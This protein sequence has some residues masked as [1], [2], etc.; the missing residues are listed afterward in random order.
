MKTR[1]ILP[2]IAISAWACANG[3]GNSSENRPTGSGNTSTSAGANTPSSSNSSSGNENSNSS[4]GGSNVGTGGDTGIGGSGPSSSSSSGGGGSNSSASGG[5]GPVANGKGESC[6]DLADLAKLSQVGGSKDFSNTLSDSYGASDDYNPYMP[7][8]KQPGC[9]PV[10]DALGYER[11]YALTLNPGDIFKA[12]LAAVPNK[13][14][15]AIYVLDDCQALSWPD[16]D[17]ST[18]CGSNEYKSQGF[19]GALGCYP[20][21]FSFE[22]P[23]LLNQK[24]TKTKTFY[25]VVDQV[26]GVDAASFVLEW[27]ID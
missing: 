21:D 12:R 19:C 3:G 11:V 7:S 23:K 17:G 22:Y 13:S 18:M 10:F 6:S 16:Y 20:L 5:S 24:P 25:I 4:A 27:Q 15:G 9:S 8:G 14:S 1:L 26:D 2:A